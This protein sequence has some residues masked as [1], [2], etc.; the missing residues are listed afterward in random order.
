MVKKCW[1]GITPELN[2]I[3][4]FS[5]PG[6][7]PAS[8][9]AVPG[10]LGTTK[11]LCQKE[12]QLARVII[13]VQA[14]PLRSTRDDVYDIC[15]AKGMKSKYIHC[16]RRQRGYGKHPIAASLPLIAHHY[17]TTSKRIDIAGPQ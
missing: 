8:D 7:P 16:D 12:L 11:L 15:S 3:P 6:L 14:I 17:S 4:E 2:A 5:S 9:V 10:R 13:M 1:N